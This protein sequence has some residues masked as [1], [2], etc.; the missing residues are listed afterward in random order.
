MGKRSENDNSG[1]RLRNRSTINSTSAINFAVPL[2]RQRM[3]PILEQACQPP[4]APSRRWPPA[5]VRN[6]RRRQLPA[7]PPPVQISQN[8]RKKINK[9]QKLVYTKKQKEMVYTS[10][11]NFKNP[12]CIVKVNVAPWCIPSKLRNTRTVLVYTKN[13]ISK[14]GE[15]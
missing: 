3:L 9:F 5:G 1:D 15:F 10:N 4:P 8:F 7:G 11:Q 12:W 14:N 2:I 13:E 6:P